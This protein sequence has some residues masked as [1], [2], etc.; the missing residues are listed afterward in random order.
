VLDI[1]KNISVEIFGIGS[2]LF[3]ILGIWI[4]LLID[5]KKEFKKENK[6][7]DEKIFQL[8]QSIAQ[9]EKYT[10]EIIRSFTVFLE[11]LDNKS[12]EIEKELHDLIKTFNETSME[13]KLNQS[14]NEN[15]LANIL[16]IVKKVENKS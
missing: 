11:K 2:V 5:E 10:A 3:I 15:L 14:K 1:I 6:E 9:S 7:K 8:L 4:K 13:I 16:E 12:D